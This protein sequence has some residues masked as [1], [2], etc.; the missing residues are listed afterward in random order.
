[1]SLSRDEILA[2]GLPTETVDVP[3]WGGKVISRGLSAS[4]L[5]DYQQGMVETG[6]NGKSRTK[7]KLDN[8]RAGLVVLCAVDEKGELIFKP[9]D[10]KALGEK[11]A[12]VIDRLWD[13]A[14]K[15]CGMSTEDEE[16][17][18]EDFAQAQADTDASD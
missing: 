3:E 4:Q 12:A 6:P 18:A 13:V 15:L 14:R 9:S 10:A 5:D 16:R 17:L 8:V 1:M 7:T 11:D 2:T